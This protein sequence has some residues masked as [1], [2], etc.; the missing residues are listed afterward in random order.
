MRTFGAIEFLNIIH[1][2]TV[3]NVPHLLQTF[4]TVDLSRNGIGAEEA[5]SLAEMLKINQ[6]KQTPGPITHPSLYHF[7]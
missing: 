4:I 3:S 5:T 7:L 6:V 2:R 1:L